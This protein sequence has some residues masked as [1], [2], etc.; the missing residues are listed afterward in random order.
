[1]AFGKYIYIMYIIFYN[2]S[3]NTINLESNYKYNRNK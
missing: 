2:S 3:K 1:M